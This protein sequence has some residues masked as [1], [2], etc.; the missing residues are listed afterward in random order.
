MRGLHLIHSA[1]NIIQLLLQLCT[2]ARIAHRNFLKLRV[3]DDN[4][5][6]ITGGNPAAEF[7]SVCGFKVL[8]RGNQNVCARIQPQIFRRPLPDQMVGNNKHTFL[9]QA[10]P[11]AL[12]CRSHH[13]KRLSSPNLV[14]Q[15]CIA[16]VQNAGNGIYLMWPQ[17]DLRVHAA[18]QDMASIVFPRTNAVKCIVIIAD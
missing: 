18:K 13:F 16:A 15:Q 10:K 4:C 1:L 12:L 17:C 9:T 2:L 3:P 14:G 6:I 11:L 7:F 5:I 8:F